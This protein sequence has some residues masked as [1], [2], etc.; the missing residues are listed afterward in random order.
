MHGGQQLWR[1]AVLKPPHGVAPLLPGEQNKGGVRG[2]RTRGGRVT[3]E[4]DGRLG[5][6]SREARGQSGEEPPSEQLGPCFY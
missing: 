3:K 1:G 6:Q 4:R 5:K 2:V